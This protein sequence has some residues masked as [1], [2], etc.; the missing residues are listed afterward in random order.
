MNAS[1]DAIKAMRWFW[2]WRWTKYSECDFLWCA[3]CD[4]LI[5][6]INLF[7]LMF[8]LSIRLLHNLYT[9]IIIPWRQRHRAQMKET[10][11]LSFALLLFTFFSPH[12][13]EKWKLCGLWNAIVYFRLCV[14]LTLC[15][16]I[17]I[18]VLQNVRFIYIG[19]V[20]RTL[21]YTK[22]IATLHIRFNWEKTIIKLFN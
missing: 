4:A 21:T 9:Q 7:A 22:C 12:S 18:F 11:S 13:H 20:V 1:F 17:Y 16:F 14:Q 15:V 3:V 10:L 19:T 6:L 5:F 2:Q 8:R